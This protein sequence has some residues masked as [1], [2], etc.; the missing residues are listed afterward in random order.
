MI[1]FQIEGSHRRSGKVT[2]AIPR[3]GG[4]YVRTW[5]GRTE[6]KRPPLTLASELLLPIVP[7]IHGQADGSGE[8]REKE[9]G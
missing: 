9:M 1:N 6:S 3:D 8:S 5:V 7:S 2:A 4:D